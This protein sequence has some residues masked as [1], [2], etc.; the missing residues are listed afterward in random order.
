MCLSTSRL[1]YLTTSANRMDTNCRSELKTV[2]MPR[3]Q[4]EM[5]V[6][7]LCAD[8]RMMLIIKEQKDDEKEVHSMALLLSETS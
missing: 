7:W 3:R 8:R 1:N 5:Q 4:E 6:N 2:L